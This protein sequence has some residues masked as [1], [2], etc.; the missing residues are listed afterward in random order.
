MDKYSEMEVSSLL[1]MVRANDDSAFSALLGR[2]TPMI[3]GVISAFDLTHTEASE[4]CSEAY[5]ALYRAALSFD[6]ANQDVTFGLY[7]RI[8]VRRSISDYVARLARTDVSI[9]EMG[10]SAFAAS[11]G[12]ERRLV[13]NETL[14]NGLLVAREVLS[15]YEYD[16]FCLYLRG[17]TTREIAQTL[18]KTAKSVDNAKGRML[19]CLRAH[20]GLFM[21]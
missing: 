13:S 4:A 1:L 16:V 19:K 7:A 5:L 12:I 15:D 10:E 17:Y 14:A 21:N 8:C 18:G 3:K 9:D 11:S 20:R 2:Y 6:I